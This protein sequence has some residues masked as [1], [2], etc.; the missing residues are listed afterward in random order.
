[1][2]AIAQIAGRLVDSLLQT[3]WQAA[4]VVGTVLLAQWIFHRQLSARWRYALWGLLVVRLLMPGLPASRFSIFNLSRAQ[5]RQPAAVDF[6]RTDVAALARGEPLP[7]MPLNASE[8]PA[9]RPI[10][11]DWRLIVGMVWLAGVL[12]LGVALLRAHARMG[13]R[14]ARTGRPRDPRLATLLKQCKQQMGLDCAVELVVTD[15]VATPALMGLR[16]PRLLL[17][18]D[19]PNTLSEAELRFVFLHELA[20]LKC[21][22][23]AAD[24]FLALLR[25]LHWFNPVIWLALARCRADRELARDAMV[26]SVTGR[27]QEQSYGQTILRLVERLGQPEPAI[28]AVG[29]VETRRQLKRRIQMIAQFRPNMTRDAVLAITLLLVVGLAT[30][31]G[32]S[33]QQDSAAPILPSAR[34][35]RATTAPST[36]QSPAE[37][38]LSRKLDQV[39]FA[40]AAFEDIITQL[41]DSAKINIVVN[42]REVE[43][44]GVT[45]R[46]SISGRYRDVTLAKAIRLVLDEAAGGPDLD[47]V[48]NDNTITITTRAARLKNAPT[49]VYDIRDLLDAPDAKGKARQLV[50]ILDILL[51]LAQSK[52]EWAVTGPPKEANGQL[53]VKA[54]E[55]NHT[56]IVALIEKLHET[57]WIQVG[58]E[59]VLLSIPEDF[60]DRHQI[61]L[62]D[63]GVGLEKG[64]LA[65]GSLRGKFLEEQDAKQLLDEV[66]KDRNAKILSSPRVT[67]LNGQQAMVSVGREVPYISSIQG[68]T[69]ADGKTDFQKQ[70]EKCFNGLRLEVQPTVS[71]DRKWVT[72]KAKAT[73]TDLMTLEKIPFKDAPADKNLYTQRPKLDVREGSTTVSIPDTGTLVLTGFRKRSGDEVAGEGKPVWDVLLLLKPTI[74]IKKPGEADQAFPLL[75]P[76]E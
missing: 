57:R 35:T 59:M 6:V 61:Q 13:R 68:V 9:M 43:P 29:V 38:A 28:G 53:T 76:A 47:Y 55:E 19:L 62:G 69:T 41:G 36:Q 12:L 67:V 27:Q 3:S 25:L 45:R 40:N 54:L 48:I 24:W 26:L 60:W 71:A 74:V 23:I 30:L 31:T 17:P 65:P 7:V 8:T 1:M 51:N 10:I 46:T 18:P 11:W 75:R 16:R 4:L 37:A 32:R 22:D 5:S 2:R 20:H 72:M 56:Q 14:I 34:V 39:R 58:V 63:V 50:D 52:E 49:R 73:L 70:T 42:W 33:A 44:A 64:A 15:A 21:R 66:K